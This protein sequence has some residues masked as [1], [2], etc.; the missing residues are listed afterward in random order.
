[1]EYAKQGMQLFMQYNPLE[2]RRYHTRFE[3]EIVQVEM[4][5]KRLKQ[6]VNIIERVIQPLFAY[7]ICSLD[8]AKRTIR[9]VSTRIEEYRQSSYVN[10][11][12]KMLFPKYYIEDMTQDLRVVT[13]ALQSVIVELETF[14]ILSVNLPLVEDKDTK[15]AIMTNIE[16]HCEVFQDEEDDFMLKDL[17]QKPVL[18]VENI[19]ENMRSKGGERILDTIEVNKPYVV[20]LSE[21]APNDN[22]AYFPSVTQAQTFLS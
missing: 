3:K 5:V 18:A 14:D 6:A 16:E 22:F 15:S 12:S 4:M 17:V 10:N 11:V 21:E 7:R 19:V 13:L 8:E 1:M 20:D 9:V 2:L